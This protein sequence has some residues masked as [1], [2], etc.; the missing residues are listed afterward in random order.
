M[1][2][3]FVTFI[4]GVFHFQSLD[5]LALSFARGRARLQSIS[6]KG[7]KL[8]LC[9]SFALNATANLTIESYRWVVD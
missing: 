6:V 4:H 3:Y 8:V 1:R 5:I 9:C 2:A 7:Q